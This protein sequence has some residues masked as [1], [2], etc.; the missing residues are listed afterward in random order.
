[1][2]TEK[3]SFKL[4]CV[5]QS[6]EEEEK[7]ED[8]RSVCVFLWF[9][10]RV[11][12]RRLSSRPGSA[13]RSS[14]FSSRKEYSSSHSSSS[15]HSSQLSLHLQNTKYYPAKERTWPAASHDKIWP[16]SMT[17]SRMSLYSVLTTCWTP[18]SQLI[19]VQLSVCPGRGE[20]RHKLLEFSR[21]CSSVD[22]TGQQLT[23]RGLREARALPV[24]EN[25]RDVS[26]VRSAGTSC[27]L[28]ETQ[29][30]SG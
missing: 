6:V 23:H 15:T 24:T 8:G 12:R 21:I 20:N 17:S 22:F 14:C 7:E 10:I 28:T 27:F 13:F 3:P 26:L 18:G 9:C 29:N 11:H 30:P 2:K 1:M 25:R 19:C 4:E 16:H 5:S